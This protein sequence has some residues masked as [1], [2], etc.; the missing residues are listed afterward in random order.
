MLGGMVGFLS[1]RELLYRRHAAAWFACGLRQAPRRRHWEV[2]QGHPGPQ[3]QG[4][5]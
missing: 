3:H 4:G 5:L 1:R 2:G